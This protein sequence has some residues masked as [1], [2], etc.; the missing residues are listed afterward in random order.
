[1]KIITLFL[2]FYSFSFAQT[3]SVTDTTS[4]I[5]LQFSEPMLLSSLTKDK[6]SVFD[7]L[8]QYKIYRLFVIAS[9]TSA[10][11]LETERLH[12]KTIITV[13]ADSVKDKAG[14]LIKDENKTFLI[15]NGLDTSRVK[16]PIIKVK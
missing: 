8:K 3:V 4:L 9:D 11:A 16:K 5:K 13:K 12:Y 1:M 2:L 10:V 15:F 7:S 14:N 6:F